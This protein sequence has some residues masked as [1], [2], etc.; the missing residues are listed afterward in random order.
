MTGAIILAA[1]IVFFVAGYRFWGNRVAGWLGVDPDRPTPAHTRTD[2]VDYVPT[3]PSVLLGHHFSSIA[4]AAPIIG[5]IAAASYGWTAVLVWI[6]LGGVFMGAVHDFSALIISVRHDGRGLG[7]VLE[8]RVGRSM[9]SL[10]LLFIF[11][12]LILVISVFTN[13]VAQTF[14]SVPET[15]TASTLFIALAVVF[16]LSVY[17]WNL[18]FV[19]ATI[20]GV[21]L[22][23]GCMVFG[24]NMPLRLSFNTWRFLLIGYIFFAST[25]P[26]QYLLQPRDFLNS[27]ILY[28]ML[29]VLVA[30][31]LVANPEF[32]MPAAP[33]WQT[34]KGPLFPLL[35]VTVA[36]GALSGFH[37]LVASGTTSKQLDNERHAQPIGFGGMLIESLLAVAAL[38]TAAVLSSSEYGKASGNPIGLFSSSAARIT[39]SIGL[40]VRFGTLFMSLS[41]AAFAMT[42]LDTATRLGRYAIQELFESPKPT[43]ARRM[44]SNRYSA[45]G[46]TVAV[47]SL[48]VFSGSATEIWPIFGA[49]NQ[50]VAALAFLTISLWLVFIRK[51]SLFALIPGIFIYAVTMAALAWNIYDFGRKEKYIL[52][53]ISAF[54]LSLALILGVTGVR[55]LTR[56]HRSKASS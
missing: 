56:A 45:T 37:S 34:A 33:A 29:A 26:V 1:S 35:F 11:S 24:Y 51:P 49:A 32:R 12:A 10:F 21:A 8:E 52:V 39:E 5:P 14:V 36:C 3:R 54:L 31:I 22:L 7:S 30:G 4:G 46:I 15:A 38:I 48:L 23:A 6:L 18:P 2:G 55:S 17:R 40:P 13:A 28:A 42:S 47:A 25:L 41:V 53:T 19:P 9:K 27:F 50:L 20:A 16:G 43:P 44:L